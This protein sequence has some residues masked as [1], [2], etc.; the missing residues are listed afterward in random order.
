MRG[1]PAFA[2]PRVSESG[3]S[4][5]LAGIVSGLAGGLLLL[6]SELPVVLLACLCHFKH[7]TAS[8]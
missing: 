2:G 8:A 6:P 5:G 7:L 4:G 3:G 1:R